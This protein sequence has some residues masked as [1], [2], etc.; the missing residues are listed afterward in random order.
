MEKS[1]FFTLLRTLK[2][3]EIPS[4]Q[5]YLKQ[6]HGGDE[7]AQ[8]V[9]DYIRKFYPHFEKEP[10]LELTYAYRKIYKPATSMAEKDLVKSSKNLSNK[11]SELHLWLKDFLLVE[12]AHREDLEGQALWLRV[13]EERGL[14][15]EH[16][17][18]AASHYLQTQAAPQKTTHDYLLEL[19]A[20][21]AHYDHLPLTKP[22]VYD[23]QQCLTTLETGAEIVS[24]KM[25]CRMANIN[26]QPAL[27]KADNLNLVPASE[28]PDPEVLQEDA[29]LLL[30]RELYQ[31]I[32]SEELEHYEH[33]VSLLAESADVLNPDELHGIFGYLQNFVSIQMRKDK[34]DVYLQK[35]H[36]LNIFGLQHHI[37]TRQSGM[38]KRQFANIVNVACSA[39]DFVWAE[40]FITDKIAL[41]PDNGREE[42]KR[43]C[44]AMIHMFKKEFEQVKPLLSGLEF[45]DPHMNIRVRAM[46][47]QLYI[48]QKADNYICL[49][50]CENF[51]LMLIRHQKP[52]SGSVDAAFAFV[53]LV[54]VLLQENVTRQELLERVEKEPVLFMRSWL[55]EKAEQ[56][57]GR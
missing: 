3:P 39:N 45:D 22:A 53:R 43:L 49:D 29:L 46:T 23:M 56:Y 4:F 34:Q 20:S 41:L 17:K 37:F 8:R 55:K 33:I 24:L 7:V 11:L 5:K 32:E 48:E 26:R 30:Y 42:I 27:T 1:K 9:F 13:L 2:A 47:I 28:K 50:H 19:A 6:M 54:K 40:D 18:L 35:S 52:S 51:R 38:H 36:E 57:K 25:R 16:A 12:K 10:K 15:S 44:R 21:Y 31:L 14:Q